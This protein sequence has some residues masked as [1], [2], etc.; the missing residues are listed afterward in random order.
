LTDISN[1]L[2]SKGLNFTNIFYAK[3]KKVA[4]I[5][6]FF[7]FGKGFGEKIVLKMLLKLSFFTYIIELYFLAKDN[8]QKSYSSNVGEIDYSLL[9]NANLHFNK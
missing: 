2:L 6:G 1:I 9:C 7:V 8:C 3:V 5:S 4:C